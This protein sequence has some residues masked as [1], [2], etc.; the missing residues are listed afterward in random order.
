MREIKEQSLARELWVIAMWLQPSHKGSRA[1]GRPNDSLFSLAS[2]DEMGE[3]E[4]RWDR[5]RRE[6]E[7]NS[8]E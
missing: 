3:R 2:V 1:V 8:D 4:G 5:G 7:N 6:K